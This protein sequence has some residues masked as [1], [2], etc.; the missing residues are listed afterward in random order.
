MD[1]NR[2][3]GI[4]FLIGRALVG[5][6][7]LQAGI[8]NILYR[9]AKAGYAASKGLVVADL[10]VVV[11]ALLLIVA[12]LCLLTGFRPRLGILAL[13]LFLIPVTLIMHNFWA[14]EGITREIES[15]AFLGNVAMLGSALVFIAIPQPWPY[16]LD[17]WLATRRRPAVR[18]ANE[19]NPVSTT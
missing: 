5:G 7:Y 9:P 18:L 13:T 10:L 15:H 19:V 2:Y 8:S 11:S 16:S 3:I 17:E 1:T 6:V 14:A 12:G 4:V